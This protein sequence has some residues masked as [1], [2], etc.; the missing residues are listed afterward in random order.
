MR[1]KSELE[2]LASEVNASLFEIVTKYSLGTAC[3]FLGMAVQPWRCR[4]Y[5]GGGVQDAP[6]LSNGYD[7]VASAARIL[8]VTLD[9]SAGQ[10]YAVR[11][12]LVDG[13]T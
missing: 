5:H 3:D 9:A 1:E 8:C 13:E 11:G 7:S 10:G 6:G 4:R 2:I 12:V